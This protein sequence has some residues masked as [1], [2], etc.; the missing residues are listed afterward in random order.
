MEYQ[1]NQRIRSDIQGDYYE[2]YCIVIVMSV[3]LIIEVLLIMFSLTK[4]RAYLTLHN[5][6]VL[7]IFCIAG[8]LPCFKS[9]Q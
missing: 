9:Q 6:L 4:P 1:F 7:L 2:Q 3:R 8:Q 5:L